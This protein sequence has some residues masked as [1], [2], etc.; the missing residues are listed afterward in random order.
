MSERS[1]LVEHGIRMPS[2]KTQW[3]VVEVRYEVLEDTLRCGKPEVLSM[4]DPEAKASLE[5]LLVA[6]VAGR[7]EFFSQVATAVQAS[8]KRRQ[9]KEGKQ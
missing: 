6:L 3:V 5:D 1:V 8:E 9:K 4:C 2:G 7:G